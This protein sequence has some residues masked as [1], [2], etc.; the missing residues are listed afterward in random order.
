ML[1]DIWDAIVDG[2]WYIVS[3]EWLGD[4]WDFISGMFDNLS[5]FS[6]IGLGF[7]LAAFGFIY[8]FSR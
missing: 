5:E 2:F 3:F 6:L 7:G 4:S 8:V 1:D